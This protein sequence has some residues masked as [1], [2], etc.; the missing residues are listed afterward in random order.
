[1]QFDFFCYNKKKNKRNKPFFARGEK[2]LNA[3]SNIV[4]WLE[5]FTGSLTNSSPS[6]AY[7]TW[8]NN[9]L[10]KRHAWQQYPNKAQF[11]TSNVAKSVQ[12]IEKSM[13]EI[14]WRD[15]CFIPC[16]LSTRIGVTLGI[17]KLSDQF[18][19]QIC[20]RRQGLLQVFFFFLSAE[21]MGR[22][23]LSCYFYSSSFHSNNFN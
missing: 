3:W 17:R 18:N 19:R 8:T 6:T 9:S 14:D 2:S 12:Q 15:S 11:N 23:D 21:L 20:R 16:Y 10:V 22:F 7:N 13:L 4:D 5:N 1:M